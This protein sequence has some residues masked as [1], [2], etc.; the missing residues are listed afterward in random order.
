[1]SRPPQSSE[2]KLQELAKALDQLERKNA[3]PASPIAPTPKPQIELGPKTKLTV[4]IMA[5]GF[6]IFWILWVILA[7]IVTPPRQISDLVAVPISA[8]ICWL[9]FQF[10]RMILIGVVRKTS[11]NR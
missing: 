8:F 7:L 5:W 4:R 6:G 2:E 9:I 11:G 1:M 3:P 10:H